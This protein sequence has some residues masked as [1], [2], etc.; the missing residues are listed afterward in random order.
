MHTQTQLSM[1]YE[2]DNTTAQSLA[3]E[4]QNPVLFYFSMYN[5]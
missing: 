5:E 3:M 1:D 2:E 4:D